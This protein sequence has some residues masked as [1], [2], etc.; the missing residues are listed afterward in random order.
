MF[1]E[2][3]NIIFMKVNIISIAHSF[4]NSY[5]YRDT[6]PKQLRCTDELQHFNLQTVLEEGGFEIVFRCFDKLK[7]D[8]P[9]AIKAYS[10]KSIHEK[11][12]SESVVDEIN[13]MIGMTSYAKKLFPL[14]VESGH[15]RHLVYFKTAE[16]ITCL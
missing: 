3:F 12:M 8:K 11:G 10:K 1:T 7:D 5:Y 15:T 2:H 14:I 4:L 6:L 9:L 16:Y 13:F